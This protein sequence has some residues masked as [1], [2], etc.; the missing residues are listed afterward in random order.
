M[1]SGMNVEEFMKSEHS[2]IFRVEL[3][4]KNVMPASSGTHFMLM[5]VKYQIFFTEFKY[6][7]IE[8]K[9]IFLL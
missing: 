4:T 5:K 7:F 6:I 3:V 9:N 8:Y 2:G 1:F